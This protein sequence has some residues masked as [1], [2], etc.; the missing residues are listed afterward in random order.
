MLAWHQSGHGPHRCEILG[1]DPG[2][3]TPQRF[4]NELPDLLSGRHVAPPSLHMGSVGMARTRRSIFPVDV[5]GNS[6]LISIISIIS[7]IIHGTGEVNI[8]IGH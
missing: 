7:G 3:L 4:L 6:S 5:L 1:N 8:S 2:T